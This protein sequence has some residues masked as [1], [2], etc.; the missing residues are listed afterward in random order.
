MRPGISSE[1]NTTDV[2]YKAMIVA[3]TLIVGEMSH[4]LGDRAY[5]TTH[6]LETAS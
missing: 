3:A 4:S 1:Q 5:V 2:G 6:K